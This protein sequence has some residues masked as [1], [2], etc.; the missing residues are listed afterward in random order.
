MSVPETAIDGDVEWV[1]VLVIFIIVPLSANA[2]L[3]V[4][5]K[6]TKTTNNQKSFIDCF[7][8]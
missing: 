8:L 4:A 7:S 2:V 6:A 5:T 1:E 3:V